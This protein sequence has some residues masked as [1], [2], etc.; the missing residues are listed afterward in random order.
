MA[1]ALFIGRFQPL[2]LGHV[3]AVSYILKREERLILGVGSSQYSGTW[4]N[5]FTAEE[6]KRMIEKVFAEERERI[7]VVF[8]PDVHD[9]SRW[10]AH[11]SS[12]VSSFDVVYTSSAHERKLFKNAGFRVCNIPFFDRSTYSATKI[13]NM[14]LKGG[15]WQALLPSGSIEVIKEV[16]GVERLRRLKRGSS[17]LPP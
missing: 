13:R 9:D 8:I 16:G 11:V 2:H 7:T 1:S 10:V 5:P 3:K 12:I 14:M 4:E 17:S 6:R 15:N